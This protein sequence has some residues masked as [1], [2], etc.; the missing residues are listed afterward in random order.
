MCCNDHKAH[1][2]WTIH[3]FLSCFCVKA[4]NSTVQFRSLK[5][6]PDH[7]LEKFR[8]VLMRFEWLQIL[9]ELLPCVESCRQRLT[10][11]VRITVASICFNNRLSNICGLADASLVNNSFTYKH[12]WRPSKHIFTNCWK[13]ILIAFCEWIKFFTGQSLQTNVGQVT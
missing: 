5:V 13:Q 9:I 2:G 12:Y 4:L 11:W 7:I 6:R 3:L 8:F 1:L 10:Q